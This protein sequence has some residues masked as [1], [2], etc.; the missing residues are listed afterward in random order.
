MNKPL[1]G[2]LTAFALLAG[3]QPSH[4]TM[5]MQKKAKELGFAGSTNCL[6]CHNEKMPTKSEGDEQR[7]R[8][9][10]GEDEGR[11][12]G[13]GSRHGLAQGLR[14]DQEVARLTRGGQK[15]KRRWSPPAPFFLKTG[16]I[17]TRMNSVKGRN[18]MS[19]L[20]GRSLLLASWLWGRPRLLPPRPRPRPT[21]TARPVTATRTRHGR[22]AR[23]SRFCPRRSRSPFM[24]R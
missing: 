11:E 12:E 22:T 3:A 14:G 8:H 20:S 4:A 5:P 10:P 21:T 17:E 2:I 7:A 15:P 24:A 9:V 16:P 23:R 18:A 6:F 19:G 1:V 13:Q